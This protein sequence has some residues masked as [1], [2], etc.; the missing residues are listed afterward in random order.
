MADSAATIDLLQVLWYERVVLTSRRYGANHG[1]LGLDRDGLV[2]SIDEVRALVN[3]TCGVWSGPLGLAASGLRPLG[4]VPTGGV[5][6]LWLHF[7]L[8]LRLRTVSFH[9][10]SGP[11]DLKPRHMMAINCLASMGRR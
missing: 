8:R 3:C 5:F 4:H 11:D 2:I 10:P 6:H 1:G 7:H 9:P